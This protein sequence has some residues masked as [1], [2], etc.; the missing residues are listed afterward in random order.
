VANELFLDTNVLSRWRADKWSPANSADLY[1]T[2]VTLQEQY[3]M[4]S[5]GG[6]KYAYALPRW[7]RPADDADDSAGWSQ[8]DIIQHARAFNV[9]NS[10]DRIPFNFEWDLTDDFVELKM[11]R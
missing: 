7:R 11:F 6:W 1:I 3:F 2:T 4:Q 10:T 8:A 9:A 5:G